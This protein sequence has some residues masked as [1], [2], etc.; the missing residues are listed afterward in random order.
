MVGW[1]IFVERSFKMLRGFHNCRERYRDLLQASTSIISIAR[2]SQRVK[3]AL[4]ETINAVGSQ[5]EP[6]LPQRPSGAGGNGEHLVIY[7]LKSLNG[8]PWVQM[9]T[10]ILYSCSQ[11]I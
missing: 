3:Q 1:V 5:E 8:C 11:R 2:S 10:Y 9:R 6:P 4:D 7:G